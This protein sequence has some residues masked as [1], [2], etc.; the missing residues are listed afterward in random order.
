M[1]VRPSVDA[2]HYG[3]MTRR[4]RITGGV[5]RCSRCVTR[6]SRVR[7]TSGRGP[8][9]TFTGEQAYAYALGVQKNPST[10]RPE[11][12]HV[13]ITVAV[14]RTYW[15]F[16]AGSVVAFVAVCAVSA[17]LRGPQVLAAVFWLALMFAFYMCFVT[18]AYE[19]A[20]YDHNVHIRSLLRSWEF[21]LS[22][23]GD[24]RARRSSLPLFAFWWTNVVYYQ[25]RSKRR[26]VLVFSPEDL[27]R[28]PLYMAAPPNL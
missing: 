7:G 28:P 25:A 20:I 19:L 8:I 18:W 21:P 27:R 22:A 24:V 3:I 17:Q 2:I 12:R 13:P 4:R 14:R 26:K 16:F 10:A 9:R 5:T 23:V 1:P 15:A 11:N 6:C